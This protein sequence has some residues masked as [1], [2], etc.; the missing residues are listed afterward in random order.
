M[1]CLF[2]I[3][4]VF[5]KLLLQLVKFD[6]INRELK[7]CLRI[8]DRGQL[9]GIINL[10]TGQTLSLLFIKRFLELLLHPGMRVNKMEWEY[11]L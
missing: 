10:I 2:L 9:Q 8:Q 7:T 4:F 1:R 6:R 5:F 11:V 3:F